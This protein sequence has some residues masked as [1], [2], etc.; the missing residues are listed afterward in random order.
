MAGGDTRVVLGDSGAAMRL[1]IILVCAASVAYGE[2]SDV[3]LAQDII[4]ANR[5]YQASLVSLKVQFRQRYLLPQ[6]GQRELPACLFTWA[7]SG[8][9]EVF[10]NDPQ[11]DFEGG[12]WARVWS[13]F[14]RSGGVDVSY[15]TFDTSLMSQVTYS[16]NMPDLLRQ[17][18]VPAFALGWRI[19]S[20][21]LNDLRGRTLV[22]LMENA[23]PS[24]LV[25][26]NAQV[27]VENRE[28]VEFPCVKWPLLRFDPNTGAEHELVCWFD[29]SRGWLP[30]MW[31]ARPVHF[32]P[33]T[34][35]PYGV[36]IPEFC[37]VDDPLQH[38]PRFFPKVI[39][40]YGL[41]GM[42]TEIDTIDCNPDLPESLFEPDI[43][44]G[45]EIIRFAGSRRQLTTY[46]GEEGELL[47]AGLKAKEF[48]FRHPGADLVTANPAVPKTF[49]AGQASINAS[50]RQSEWLSTFMLGFGGVLVLAIGFLRLRRG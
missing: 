1:L 45:A 3:R 27:L 10:Y 24:T 6:S 22:G 39:L 32:D 15:F 35:R 31:L 49:T 8:D 23:D 48:D 38:S 36:A 17:Y 50:P 41:P 26:E 33:Q 29:E 43:T 40:E 13:A 7:G 47:N 20:G 11:F 18:S 2:S 37:S 46:A 19:R 42:V 12:R 34:V 16:E 14:S 4:R 9:Q 44:D 28:Y 21:I 30:R 5:A 25:R